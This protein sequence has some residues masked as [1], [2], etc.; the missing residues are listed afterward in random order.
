MNHN[1]STED[2]ACT[3]CGTEPFKS[4]IIDGENTFCCHGCHAVYQ[5]LS[6]KGELTA[7]QNHPIFKQAL[8][9]G[10]ISNP[11][12]LEEISKKTTHDSNEETKKNYFEVDDMWC[13]SCAEVIKLVLLRKKG[14][15]NCVIDYTTDLAS[16]EYTPRYISKD[17][18]YQTIKGLGYLPHPLQ[19]EEKQAV[20]FSLWIRFIISAFCTLNIM[21]FSYPIY[22]AYFTNDEQGYARLFV[23]LSFFTSLP[24][25]SFCGWPIAWR[26]WNSLRVGILGMETLVV[27][28]V[29]ASLLLSIY[30]LLTGGVHVYF[31]SMS[32]IVS[33]VLLGRIIENKAKFSAK[34]SLLRLIRSTPRRGRKCFPDGSRRFV[35]IK[36]VVIGDLL[37]VFTG[38]KVV[39]DGIVESGE[40]CCDESLMTGE[41]L[42]VVKKCGDAILGGTFLQNGSIIYRVKANLEDTA[43]HKIIDVVEQD[44]GH[45]ARYTRAA[46]RIV[47]GF[48]PIVVL[49][50][51][52]SSLGAYYF[53]SISFQ[54][55]FLRF[56][57]V[58]LISCP[59]AIGIAAPLA[60]SHLMHGLAAMG[61]LVRNR[62]CLT[63]LGQESIFVF[64][65]TGT[66][67]RGKFEVLNGISD[68]NMEEQLALKGLTGD[69]NHPISIAIDH[70]LQTPARKW[71]RVE[72]YAGRGLRGVDRDS[73][74]YLGSKDFLQLQGVASFD[75][76]LHSTKKGATEV[77]F[78]LNGAK[79]KKLCLGDE[80][81]HDS[82]ETVKTLYPIRTVLLSG[83]SENAV[84]AVAKECGFTDFQA[85]CN[86]LQKRDFIETLRKEGYIVAMLGDGINDA[87]PLTAANI[88]ISVVSASDI[89]IQVSDILLTTDKL[90]VIKE[91]RSLARK[92]QRIINQNLFWAFAYNVVGIGFASM[93]YLSP[94]YAALAMVLSS[95]FVVVNA[96]RLS[97]E[98]HDK[99]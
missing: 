42:P 41:S 8:K 32:V 10:L 59:C 85:R 3:L 37:A 60:E 44:I 72:E 26:C 66:I 76:S 75:E 12:L 52:F 6:V 34:D 69:S 1:L 92:G 82:I 4:S 62:G 54:D 56:V 64:D 65:K 73:V 17:E 21:M 9:S 63:L 14:V 70:A 74:A 15:E 19:G 94:I 43:L 49:I 36:E 7:S 71:E 50:A 47:R 20:P 18:I 33:L 13:P 80:I 23:W 61:V 87:P 11:N 29:S 27:I 81:R 83:D 5:I 40:G 39:L 38:E 98:N 31:D 2:K 77:Y 51:L 16:V 24:V 25:V 68:L 67:T 95:L 30:N 57:S 28:G 84:A 96:K 79:A 99:A 88:G 91:M 97:T 48:V 35:P 78:S 90:H 53:L 46:D 58:L 86:P 22:A 55:A 89:S 93:G 45:K